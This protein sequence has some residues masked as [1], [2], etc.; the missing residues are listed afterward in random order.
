MIYTPVSLIYV[1]M[2]LSWVY[3]CYVLGI[4]TMV[5]QNGRDRPTKSLSL[6]K[7]MSLDTTVS[8]SL[9]VMLMVLLAYWL[10]ICTAVCFQM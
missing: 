7:R 10:N 2:Y 5:M 3:F 9:P 6:W 8:V 1:S 4:W